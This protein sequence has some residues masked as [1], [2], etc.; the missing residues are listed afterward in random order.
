[1]T[2]MAVKF[3]E[4]LDAFDFVSDGQPFEHDAYLCLETGV[5][6]YHSDLV[7]LEEAL[8]DDIDTPGKYIAIGRD[9]SSA[10]IYAAI[11]QGVVSSLSRWG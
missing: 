11:A 7:D 2:R 8:P 5:I 3:D 6:H 10:P 1:M 4:L 9:R